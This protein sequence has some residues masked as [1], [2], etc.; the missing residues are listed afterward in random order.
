MSL[1]DAAFKSYM[2]QNEYA[3][4]SGIKMP[5]QIAEMSVDPLVECDGNYTFANGRVN[6][7]VHIIKQESNSLV[8]LAYKVTV[9]Y[10]GFDGQMAVARW[11]VKIND[12]P[13]LASQN[14]D[15]SESFVSFIGSSSLVF[16]PAGCKILEIQE[17]DHNSK[18]ILWIDLSKEKLEFSTSFPMAS[19][20]IHALI[21]KGKFFRP[22]DDKEV[23]TILHSDHAGV[24]LYARNTEWDGDIYHAKETEEFVKCQSKMIAM[25]SCE[26]KG[27]EWEIKL[28]NETDKHY[29]EFPDG[30]FTACKEHEH[31]VLL[32]T[33]PLDLISL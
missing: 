13:V 23:K 24:F 14:Y 1:H 22:S 9:T 31:L 29:L 5:T 17:I 25:H 7:K 16:K 32:D 2:S 18:S 11:G 15:N 19:E 3:W 20:K 4:E 28:P 21:Q 26:G 10:H 6:S 8:R 30:D 12:K 27:L 33:N